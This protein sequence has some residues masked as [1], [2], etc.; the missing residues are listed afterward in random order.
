MGGRLRTGVFLSVCSVLLTMFTMVA[1]PASPALALQDTITVNSTA[2]EGFADNGNF[3]EEGEGAGSTIC[4]LRA[5]V[6]AAENVV[7]APVNEI[8]VEVPAG[9]FQLTKG[10]LEV[11]TERRKSCLAEG[12][13]R[14]CPIRLQ[15]AGAALTFIEGTPGSRV[16]IANA[17]GAAT[18]AGATIMGGSTTYGGG[19]LIE[20]TRVTL[21]EDVF[22]DD[23]ASTSGGAVGAEHAE[24]NVIDTA[25]DAN[26]AAGTQGGAVWS[27]DS[28]E[29][30]VRSTFDANNARAGGALASEGS[31]P[32]ST[33]VVDSTIAD[34]DA[35]YTGGGVYAGPG[36][37]VRLDDSTIANNDAQQGSAVGLYGKATLTSE[38]SILAG[39]E[40]VS[41][42]EES[43]AIAPDPNIVFSPHG[44]SFAGATP[45]NVDPWL[46]HLTANGGVGET[47]A[48]LS[49]SPA[50]N[51]GGASC[52][53]SD[54]E[55]AAVDERGLA[56]PQ[57]SACDLGAYESGADAAVT[58]T[59]SPN[60]VTLGETVTVTAEV[61]DAGSDPLSGTQA[62]ISLPAGTQVTSAASGCLEAFGATTTLACSVGSL[63]PGAVVP[64]TFTVRAEPL[65][66]LQASATVRS[67][68][69]DFNPS[70][71]SAT[72][73][74]LVN[75][76][77]GGG[78]G[79]SGGN[80]SAE[81]S[82]GATGAGGSGAGSSPGAGTSSFVGGTTLVGRVL[83]ISHGKVL[84]NLS[85]AAGTPGG[86][87]DALGLYSASGRLPAVE[88]GSRHKSTHAT[89]LATGHA[90]IAAG[91]TG[92]VRLSL[93]ASGRRLAQAHK[94]FPARVLLSLHAS[95]GMTITHSYA[96]KVR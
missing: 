79:G 28:T 72:A 94:G 62:T 15:G 63:A 55:G 24:L 7:V 20:Q 2:D 19:L 4:P 8:V 70:N 77:G 25:M 60:P 89:A 9:H 67:E 26:A 22:T 68:Q 3:C 13:E 61:S 84:L 46:G 56:R 17:T 11:G 85:C 96:V 31:S 58:L 64:L 40:A 39:E 93:D 92:I 33:T 1:L 52:S 32:A 36:V 69:A 29:N 41:C 83:A 6:E 45:M 74:T 51:A 71:D 48:L 12:Q 95:K 80:T 88:A 75:V 59:E 38:G 16:L 66:S 65:G 44:C 43:E 21:R 10:S 5:A 47:L 78:S 81:S 23:H 91:A 35:L 73:A 54:V 53:A 27:F 49:G 82:G 30:I 87:S 57:G 42:V 76:A 34:N 14:T 18:I 86:C 90:H 50:L 37:A